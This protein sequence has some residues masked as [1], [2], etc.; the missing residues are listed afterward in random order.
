MLEQA[1]D[2]V[3]TL[4]QQ[5]P[6]EPVTVW[7]GGGDYVLALPFTLSAADSGTANAPVTYRGMDGQ[8]A[9]LINARRLTASDFQPVTDAAAL[10]R[11]VEPARGKIVALDLKALGIRHNRPP[12]NVYNDSGGLPDIYIDG[13]RQPLSRYPNDGY[14]M[15]KTVLANGDPK[16]GPGIFEYREEDYPQFETWRKALDRGVWLKGYWR[17]VWQNESIRVKSIDT[18]AHTVTFTQGVP[19]GIGNKYHRPHGDGKETYW[20]QNL[21]EAV[22]EPGEWCIDY[23]DQKIY[24]YPPGPLDKA[25]IFLGDSDDPAVELKNA[26]NIVLRG[27][28]IEYGLSDGISIQGGEN[29]LVAGCVVRN[30]DK[31]AVRVE[32]GTHHTVLSCDL[33]HLGAGGVWLSGGDEKSNPRVPAGHEILN[34]HIHHFSEIEKIYTPGVNCGFTGG[35]GGGHH[36]AVG[37]LVAHNLIHDTPHGGVLFSSWD[38]VFE[39]NEVF[40]YC[41]V[42]N[43]LGAFYSYD[44]FDRMGNETFRYNLIHS[45]ANGDGIYFDQDHRDMHIY[46]NIIDLRTAEKSSRGTGMLYKIGLQTD[47]KYDNDPASIQQLD[48]TNNIAMQCKVGFAFFVPP[49][50]ASKID[51]NVAI[52]CGAPWQWTAVSGGKTQKSG[53]PLATGTNI[54]YPD[55]PGFADAAH[56]DFHLKPGAQL[57]KDLP[58]FQPIPVD[59][60]GL[61]IDEYR[62]TLPTNEEIDRFSEHTSTGGGSYNVEDRK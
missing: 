2:A 61:Y 52:S 35:G 22:D 13:K 57:L 23:A 3:R 16:T 27:L 14:M 49:R 47:P 39:Y 42:S 53:Q 58:D 40:R 12:P 51:H 30:I 11:I 43:D 29:D 46:G 20:L 19:G 24:L 41:L 59:K 21:L 34:N 4:R 9:R 62:K 8:T 45:S 50:P 44:R 33:Y 5:Q 60:I 36:T 32:G 26:S 1:R 18:T 28:T 54:A 7:I 10:A 56:L 31:Y 55:D 15:M 48:C 25:E 37:M 17:V 38:N 6:D